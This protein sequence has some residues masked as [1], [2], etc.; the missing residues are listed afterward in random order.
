[1]I[2]LSLFIRIFDDTRDSIEHINKRET[3]I[4]KFCAEWEDLHLSVLN[5]STNEIKYLTFLYSLIRCSRKS[6]SNLFSGKCV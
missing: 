6:I 3:F 1:M 4:T 5:K 2:Q